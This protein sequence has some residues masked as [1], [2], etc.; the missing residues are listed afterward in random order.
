[1]VSYRGSAEDRET[2]LAAGADVY[3]LKANFD[4]QQLYDA[5]I[6]LIG[7]PERP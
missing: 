5:V 4:E 2:A 7:G 1:M 3:L 6:R